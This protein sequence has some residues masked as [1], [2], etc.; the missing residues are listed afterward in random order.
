[1]NE[2]ENRKTTEKINKTRKLSFYKMNTI[3][4]LP[5]KLMNMKREKMCNMISKKK[6]RSLLPV[7]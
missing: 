6:A 4:K 1:M 2:I 7:S 3:D 5:P